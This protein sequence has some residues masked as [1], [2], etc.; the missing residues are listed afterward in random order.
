[1]VITLM[2]FGDRCAAMEKT[3]DLN[4]EYL[5][6]FLPKMCDHIQVIWFLWN[7]LS[8]LVKWGLITALKF[9]RV[10]CLLAALNK[11]ATNSDLQNCLIFLIKV[12][13]NPLR[14]SQPCWWPCIAIV[15]WKA[16]TKGRRPTESSQI[17]GQGPLED[18]HS[19]AL[20][21]C[22]FRN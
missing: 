15:A 1:M 17:V 20:Q 10:F 14:W 11:V 19:H 21:L 5:V 13:A 9:C 16:W 6:L 3:L 18:G 22:L 7:S 8:S 12:E 2:V 4:Q